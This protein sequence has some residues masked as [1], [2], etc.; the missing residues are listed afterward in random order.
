MYGA[1]SQIITFIAKIGS[2]TALYIYTIL[3][4]AM[5]VTTTNILTLS[6]S[7]TLYYCATTSDAA[8]NVYI[9]CSK[10]RYCL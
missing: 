4:S 9:V 6:S 3:N 7:S 10:I 1:S 8:L 2:Q 5:T